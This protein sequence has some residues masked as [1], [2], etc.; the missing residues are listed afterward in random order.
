MDLTLVQ[1]GSVAEWIAAL[2]TV[3][4]LGGLWLAY[5]E[6]QGGVKAV[7]AQQRATQAELLM[8]FN[9]EWRTSEL[10]ES[11]LY[12]HRLRDTWTAGGGSL[13][14]LARSWVDEHVDAT[15]GQLKTEWDHRRRLA[16]FLRHTG[17]LLIHGYLE[18]DDVFSVNPEAG[19]FLEVLIPIEN[20]II[21]RF[22]ALN[23][24]SLTKSVVARK[25]ELDRLWELY[26][27]WSATNAERNFG[28]HPRLPVEEYPGSGTP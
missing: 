25:W 10:Y 5:R 22:G 23:A 6:V 7:R 9:T 21:E 11:T 14:E 15:S 28:P 1:W 17:Y 16:Q 18:P 20:A 3:A 12:I 24:R 2:A 4:F 27:V 8:Q 19:R 13:S 26:E